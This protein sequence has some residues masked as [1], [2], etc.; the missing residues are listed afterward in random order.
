MAAI[1]SVF[2]SRGLTRPLSDMAAVAR[3]LA[4][5]S[6]RQRIATTARDEI[7]VLGRALDHMADQLESTIREVTEDRRNS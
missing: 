7:G 6:L 3:Q 2:L 4:A 1:L 5:G